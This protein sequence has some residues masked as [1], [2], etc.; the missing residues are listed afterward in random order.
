MVCN[1]QWVRESY[2]EG[3]VAAGDIFDPDRDFFIGGGGGPRFGLPPSQ[4]SQLNMI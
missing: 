4:Y 3:D 1:I 2:L